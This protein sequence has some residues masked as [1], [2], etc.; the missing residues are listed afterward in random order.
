MAIAKKVTLQSLQAKAPKV[1]PSTC[2]N[3][4]NL[5]SL[6]E[7]ARKLPV[8]KLTKFC[9]GMERLRTSNDLLRDSGIYWYENCK[10]LVAKKK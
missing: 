10:E 6:V 4:D 1:P 8:G 2:S 9:K 7:D 3:I 5:I